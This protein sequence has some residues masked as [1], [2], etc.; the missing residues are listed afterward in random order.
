MKYDLGEKLAVYP[1][2]VYLVATY[3]R[4]GNPNVMTVG[5]GGVCNS[6]PPCVSISVRPGAHTHHALMERMAFT[7]NIVTES[8]ANEAAYC[9][10]VSG[11]K[12]NKFEKTGLTPIKSEFVDAPYI[13]EIPI[14]LECKII[15]TNEIGS[16]TQF[17]GQ[18]INVKVDEALKDMGALTIEHL[19]PIV[20]G[21]GNDFSYYGIGTNIIPEKL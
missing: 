8:F 20:Y 1:T 9:G 18:I 5:W 6:K 13:E 15:Q 10:R 3:D 12:V 4:D 21:I 11:R 17:I 2:P 7:L 19:R 14:N 16:H